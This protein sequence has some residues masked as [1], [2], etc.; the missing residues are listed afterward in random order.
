MIQVQLKL[1]LTKRQE[2]TLNTWLWQLTGL[3][4]WAVRK[5]ELD[6]RDKIYHSEFDLKMLVVGH[7]QRLEMPAHVLKGMLRTVYQSWQRC[8]K[9]QSRKPQL[10]GRRNT[11]NSIPLAV[12][13][14]TP[15]IV[16]YLGVLKYHKQEIPEGKVKCGRIIKR[17]SGWHLC[18]FIEAEAKQIPARAQGQVGIDPGFKSLLTLSNGEVF[19][20]PREFEAASKR[21]AQAQRGKNRRLTS[22]LYERIANRRKDRNHKISRQLVSDNALIAFSADRHKGIA[23]RFGK[24]VMSS[25][26]AQLRQML[27][28]KS[29]AGGRRYVEVDSKFSTKRCSNCGSLSGPSG[30]GNLAVRRWACR[31]C[32]VNHDRDCNA[33]MNTLNVALGMSVERAA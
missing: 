26:H 11:L 33:A 25:G 29:R 32:G 14:K 30:L 12:I 21:L 31:D 10:K 2:A 4:N 5:I 6:A 22:R 3:W 7:A 19:D 23:N 24:S 20:H 16:G 17:A 28:Y 15:N 18:L 9:K 13:Q 8:F 27:A 1:K